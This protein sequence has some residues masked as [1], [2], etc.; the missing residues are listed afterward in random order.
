MI[1]F[2]EIFFKFLVA[3]VYPSIL[4]LVVILI[5]F[6]WIRK[7]FSKI[8]L[9]SGAIY[10]YLSATGIISIPLILYLE[11]PMTKANDKRILSN[12]AMIVLGGGISY[13]PKDI[14][15][16]F[17][18]DARILEAY[19]I[20]KIAKANHIQYTIFLSGGYTN[21]SKSISEAALY[22]RK[23]IMLGISPQYLIV[24]NK[25]FNTYQNGKYLQPILQ[26]Y[27]FKK[28]LLVTSALHM[29]RSQK[30][31]KHFD[32]KTVPAPSDYPYPILNWL[33]IAYNLAI[34]S[35]VLHEYT[36]ILRFE[37]Y[38]IFNFN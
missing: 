18:S 30:Y 20:Y 32:I 16:L 27:P 10:F 29:R 14:A 28:Y 9:A 6:M 11:K 33:P 24:E 22:K 4:L 1:H 26:K 3:I 12:R 38:N 5:F 35:M 36:G 15:S 7:K 19:R 34:Q 17:T 2:F 21:K 23:L 37:L 8:L 31:L 13:S 25:S